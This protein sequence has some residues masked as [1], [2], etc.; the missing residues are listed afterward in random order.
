MGGQLARPVDRDAP[1]VKLALEGCDRLGCRYA[2]VHARLDRVVLGRQ[3]E[4]V[5]AH[6]MKHAQTHAAVEVG[7]RVTD[8]VDLE[9]ADVRLAARVGKH[10]QH[11]GAAP[12]RAARQR[13]GGRAD[14]VVVGDLPGPLTR[15]QLLPAGLDLVGVVLQLWHRSRRLAAAFGGTLAAPPVAPGV[16]APQAR[17]ERYPR[18]GLPLR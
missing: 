7:D 2:W 10:L 15:P 1:G 5:I 14:V 3:A 8:R 18:D 9:V 17:D 16:P 13:R 4:G 6:R 11:I 12:A